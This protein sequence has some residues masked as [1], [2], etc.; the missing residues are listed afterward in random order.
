MD[1]VFRSHGCFDYKRVDLPS[2]DVLPCHSAASRILCVPSGFHGR[3]IAASGEEGEEEEEK[4]RPSYS[5]NETEVLQEFTWSFVGEVS[6]YPERQAIIEDVMQLSPDGF[7]MDTFEDSTRE[8]G[9]GGDGGDG[10]G[11]ISLSEQANIM[12]RSILAFISTSLAHANIPWS[13][14]LFE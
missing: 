14:K 9:D 3:P 11:T 2:E 7:V 12:R 8:G 5:G 1:F 10:G 4:A 13:E 6:N